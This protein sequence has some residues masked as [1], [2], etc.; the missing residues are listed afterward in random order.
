MLYKLQ[1]RNIKQYRR[2]LL[3]RKLYFSMLM[4]LTVCI[5]NAQINPVS[6]TQGFSTFVEGNAILFSNET[7]GN[8][9]IGGDLEFISGTSYQVSVNTAGNV[10]FGIDTRPTSLLVNGTV[11]FNGGNQIQINS[12]GW[13]KIGNCTGINVYDIDNNNASVNTQISAGA[14]NATPRIQL[15]SKQPANTV[16]A[17]NLIDFGAAFDTLR[18]YS[19]SI[20][21]CTAN[22]YFSDQNG[23]PLADPNN[24]QATAKVIVN[25][26]TVNILNT[27]PAALDNIQNLTFQNLSASSPIVINVDGG[28]SNFNWTVPAFGG[29]TPEY[30]FW[31][32]VNIPVLTAVGG[33]TID[34]TIY[35][36]NSIFYKNNSANVQGNVIVKGL[37]HLSGEIHEH[38]W[39]KTLQLCSPILLSCNN[40]GIDTDNDGIADDCD[41]DDD[42]DGI[43]DANEGCIEC[44]GNA[45]VNGNFE[46]NTLNGGQSYAQI[47]E[48]NVDG[49]FTTSTDDKIEIWRDGYSNSSGGAVPAQTGTFFAEIN[50]TQ[51]G[52]LYQR[53]CTRPGAQISWSVWHRGRSGIDQAVVRIGDDLVTASVQTTMS[54][55]NNSWVQYSGVYN[56]PINQIFTYFIFE[57]VN[58]ASGNSTIGNF[59]DNIVI[60]E[61]TAGTCL[62]TDGDGIPNSK[63]LDSDGDG[64][65]DVVESGG[66]DANNDGILDGNGYDSEGLVTGGNGD[67]DGVTGAETTASQIII[68][69]TPTNQTVKGGNAVGFSINATASTATNYNNGTPIYGSIGNGNTDLRYQWYI[70]N[71]NSGGMLLNDDAIFSGTATA[72]LNISNT[73]GYNGYDFYVLVSHLSNIC[74]EE[75]RFATLTL[76]ENCSNG[77]DDDGDGLPDCSDSDCLPIQPDVIILD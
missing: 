35:A 24:P 52:A 61:I 72:T 68:N 30:I 21:N 31:N 54:T 7:E 39:T 73:E 57:S 32:F 48:A 38:P 11:L 43:L 10:Y 50:A 41:D 53:I 37:S 20:A 16:C 26:N 9:A 46:I 56:V 27:T 44:R 14:Y 3:N 1:A 4:T 59:V 49:W 75:V 55:G 40:S 69:A 66:I 5:S 15:N 63:D 28:G 71:P 17:S 74:L 58:T 19:E 23:N 47:N 45:F 77:V 42:N 62:D 65:F 51:M 76:T 34:G 29:A 12:N 36:P 18:A 8:M 22:L 33:N 67:Y 70:G 13:V 2:K 25:A 6:P 60:Q 64:C